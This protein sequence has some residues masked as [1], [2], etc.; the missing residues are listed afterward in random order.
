MAAGKPVFREQTRGFAWYSFH[1]TERHCNNILCRH[2][3]D[4]VCK[5]NPKQHQQKAHVYCA[6]N[7]K[8][9]IYY[10]PNLGL[11]RNRCKKWNGNDVPNQW[12]P[13]FLPNVTPQPQSL[14]LRLAPLISKFQKLSEKIIVCSFYDYITEML[15]EKNACPELP[16]GIVLPKKVPLC[17]QG[18][19][20][21]WLFSALLT[22]LRWKQW[23]KVTSTWTA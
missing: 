6:E 1:H 9:I 12:Q 15:S 10:C 16:Q 22:R 7:K 18:T 4:T 19:R 23:Q 8:P 13:R 11:G 17:N 14:L 5:N 20:D 3:M 2:A 21:L